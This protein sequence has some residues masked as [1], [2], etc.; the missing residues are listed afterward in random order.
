MCKSCVCSKKKVLYVCYQNTKV[1]DDQDSGI[2]FFPGPL[3]GWNYQKPTWSAYNFIF[4]TVVTE[5]G[6]GEC[7]HWLVSEWDTEKKTKKTRKGKTTKRH[8]SLHIKASLPVI[9]STTWTSNLW[10]DSNVAYTT[11]WS[12]NGNRTKWTH[13]QATWARVSEQTWM[14]TKSWH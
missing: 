4:R 13:H 2:T 14:K 8:L 9:F 3:H 1:T 11:N 7:F 6:C 10:I 5:G 12:L